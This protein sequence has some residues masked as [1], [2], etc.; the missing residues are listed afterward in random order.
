MPLRNDILNPIPGANPSGENLR[1]A[2]VYDK[3]KEARR[4]DEDVPQGEWATA[5]KVAD[6]PL[7]VKLASEA[8]ATKSKD[9]QL[10]A[11]LTEALLRREGVA[12]LKDG[13]ELIRAMLEQFWDTLYPELEDGDAELRATPLDWIGS[14]LEQPIKNSPLTRSG[15]NWFQYRESRTVG[16]E[17]DATTDE[18]KQARQTAIDE[19]KVTAE[20]FDSAVSATPVEFLQ[21]LEGTYDATLELLDGLGELCDDRFGDVSP[22]FGP[23]KKTLEEVRHTVH[24]LLVSKGQPEAPPPAA[25]EEEPQAEAWAESGAAVAAAPARALKP[26]PKALGAAPTSREE[27]AAFAAVAAAFLRGEDAY[28]PAPYLLLRGLR[29]GELRAGGESP[30]YTLL[31]APPTEIRQELKRLANESEWAQVLETAESAMAAE[32]GRAWLDLQRYTCR[33]CYE[34]GYEA[35]SKAVKSELRAL[36][37]DI[38]GLTGMT[39]ADDTPTANAET[40]SWIQEEVQ[41]AP[42]PAQEQWTPPPADDEQPAEEGVEAPPDAYELAMQSVRRGQ[43]EEAIEMLAAEVS[44]ERSPRARF[45][46][47]V[48][49]AQI[50]LASGHENVAYPILMELAAEIERRG[51][52]DWEAPDVLAHPLVL[53]YRCLGKMEGH[54]EEERRKLYARICCLDPVQALS[55]AR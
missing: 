40:L 48:Q 8:I 43:P 29:W 55:C 36:L 14:R 52:A 24:M 47:K 2:P 30:D 35:I 16:Y 46:R 41:T 50:C 38:P 37:A 53:L 10:A 18:K 3:I 31:A 19:G 44:H 39:L 13:L 23:L 51:L 20:M 22:S 21:S 45:Q 5:R 34:L 33:A 11:W 9:L 28:N 54:S 26:K 7:V 42:A 32:Y 49:L 15:L 25:E 4:E 17:N 1:Y 6:W 27:A 12:G